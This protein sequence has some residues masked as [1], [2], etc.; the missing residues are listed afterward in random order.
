MEKFAQ[1]TL[2]T[3]LQIWDFVWDFALHATQ[4]SV[5]LLLKVVYQLHI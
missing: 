2:I 4:F 3:G 1:D 5:Y